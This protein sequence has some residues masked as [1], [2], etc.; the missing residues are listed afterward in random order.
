MSDKKEC[1]GGRC[2]SVQNEIDRNLELPEEQDVAEMPTLEQEEELEKRFFLMY[3]LHMQ[4]SEYDALTDLQRN[5]VIQRFIHQKKMEKDIIR[6]QRQSS[7]TGGI[8]IPEPS[9]EF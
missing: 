3:H 6:Q 7:S 2:N 1:C 5:W 8:L 4:W 9:L